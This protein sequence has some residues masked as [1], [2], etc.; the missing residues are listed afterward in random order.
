MIKTLYF[1]NLAI[2]GKLIII[3][4]CFLCF[5]GPMAAQ[6]SNK[7]ILAEIG[8]EK[9]T[10]EEFM[11]VFRK[12]NMLT[13]TPDQ[14]AIKEYLD[15]YVNFRLKVK[16]AKM[17]GY[18]TLTSFRQ[19]LNGYRAQ[20]AKP[21]M[22]DEKA[23]ERLIKE[24]WERSKEDLRASHILVRVDKDAL[25]ADT[26]AA[27]QK[28]MKI[29]ERLSQGEAFANV[30]A[31]MSEDPSA[32]DRD[33]G[34]RIIRGNRGDLGYF[35]AFDMIYPFENAAYALRV[36]EI[37]KPVRTEFGYHIILL[38]DRKPALGKVLAAHILFLNP[39][40]AAPQDSVQLRQKAQ[41]VYEQLNAGISFDELAATYSDDRSTADKGG[42]LQWFGANRMIPSFIEEIYKLGEP[43]NY[44]P[45]FQTQ[46]GWHIVKLLDLQKPGNY[47]EAYAELKEKVQKNERSEVIKE[48]LAK[49]IKKEYGFKEKPAAFK[50]FLNYYKDDT[51]AGN[52]TMPASAKLTKQ[53]F[54]IGKKKYTQKNFSNYL[55]SVQKPARPFDLQGQLMSNYHAFVEKELL[56]FEDRQLE[57]KYPEFRALMNEYHDGILLFELTDKKIW[58]KAVRDTAGLEK[59]YHEHRYNYMWGERADASVFTFSTDDKV[60]FAR[61]K[62]LAEQQTDNEEILSRINKDS[63]VLMI[64]RKIFSKGDHELVDKVE[65]TYGV[66]EVANNDGRNALVVIHNT[67]EPGP[68]ELNDARGLVTA[69]YQAY[70]EKEWINELRN[71]YPV[72]INYDLIPQIKL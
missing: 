38:T 32:R 35:T 64:Q 58:S 24:A 19:E 36:N 4:V 42:V 62:T 46:F 67:L 56:D 26:L 71:K 43:G 59:Y 18:D 2:S 55:A 22:V 11:Q 23:T 61:V 66:K 57:K 13:D 72:K 21:Y 50:P 60:T 48:S 16:E 14:A 8:G 15:L 40:G 28:A 6:T 5:S 10:V 45:P 30:A 33:A 7:K 27:Y 37:S 1:N 53:L 69:D 47:K 12:N 17:L 25:P 31:E 68:K 54:S 63:Q 29:W 65:W 41:K 44:S 34:D 70:L 52:W 51:L 49:R 20:L 39:P 3:A 9:V